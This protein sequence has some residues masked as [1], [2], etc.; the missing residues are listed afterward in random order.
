[1]RYPQFNY[2]LGSA[3]NNESKNVLASSSVSNVA[4]LRQS[5]FLLAKQVPS[6]DGVPNSTESPLVFAST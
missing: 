2:A 1:M 6:T 4:L 5:P 3:T